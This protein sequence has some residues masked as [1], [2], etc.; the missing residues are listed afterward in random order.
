MPSLP[1]S[2][3]KASYFWSTQGWKIGTRRKIK[4]VIQG[5]IAVNCCSTKAHKSMVLDRVHPRL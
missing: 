2:E 1:Q 4:P 5:E 3:I